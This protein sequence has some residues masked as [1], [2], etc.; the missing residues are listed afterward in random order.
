MNFS[1]WNGLRCLAAVR[2][3]SWWNSNPPSEIRGRKSFELIF[4]IYFDL[5]YNV[6]Y[7]FRIC[8]DITNIDW[9]KFNYPFLQLFKR[10][11]FVTIYLSV[12][13]WGG[14]DNWQSKWWALF[15]CL[16]LDVFARNP[17]LHDINYISCNQWLP[18]FL[19]YAHATK[20]ILILFTYV[21]QLQSSWGS[22]CNRSINREVTWGDDMW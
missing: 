14:N 12:L 22:V 18:N 9:E 13:P 2:M 1:T 20:D 10:Q 4:K 5:I 11:I 8:N 7:E 15:A 19:R 21:E 6:I 16:F 3:S 17:D